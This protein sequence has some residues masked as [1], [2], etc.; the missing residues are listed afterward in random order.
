VLNAS[1][2]FQGVL[3]ASPAFNLGYQANGNQQR[4]DPFFSNSFFINQNFLSST[5]GLPLTI[6]P[7]TFPD[8]AQFQFGMAQQGG[9]SI[10]RQIGQSFKFSIGYTYIHGEHLNRPR[11]TNTPNDPLLIRNFTRAAA[12]GLAASDPRT[13]ALPA[14]GSAASCPA[15]VVAAFPAGTQFINVAG[16]GSLALVAPGALGSGFTGA[17]CGGANVGFIGTPA[18]F[19]YFR[20]SGPNPSF[21]SLGLPFATLQQL[22]TLGGFPTGKPGVPVPFSDM[23]TQESTGSSVYHGLTVSI[24]K[25]FTRHFE[26]LSSYTWSHAIDD[27]TDLQSLLVP[28]DNNNPQLDRSNSTFDQRHRWVTSGVFNSPYSWKDSGFLHKF[29]ADSTVA[30][31]V[32]LSSGRP[33]NVLTGTDFNMDFSP[34]TDRPSVVPTG[35]AGAISSTFIPGVAFALPTVCSTA[36]V[37]GVV[38]P[39]GCTGNLGRNAFVRPKYFSWDMR[40]SRKIALGDRANL[41]LIADMFNLFNRNNTSDVNVLCDPLA[42]SC[43][44]GQPTAAFDARQ[45]QFAA[46]INF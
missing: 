29:L 8:S 22:A 3:N 28:Q 42:G 20:A 27:S 9:L 36:S 5:T 13:I 7:F 33:Y 4:F 12:I 43:P 10:E 26:F 38:P 44:A 34:F 41:E 2:L 15:P 40:L 21:G 45:F 37:A 35:T 14:S 17:N 30:P 24:S 23:Q 6:L 19:N 39:L 32:E 46:K 31:I 1:T 25:R 18:I 16:G 11:N